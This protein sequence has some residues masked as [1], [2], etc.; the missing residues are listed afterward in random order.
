MPISQLN[1][2]LLWARSGNRCA[3]CK[4][5][6][7]LDA[8]EHDD[9]SVVGDECHIVA[10]RLDGA[11]GGQL[12]P[13]EVDGYA[14]LILLC[15]IDHKRVDDQ[16][17]E[18]PSEKL[19]AIKA[20]HEAWVYR[21]LECDVQRAGAPQT[22]TIAPGS[23]RPVSAAIRSDIFFSHRM[24]AAFPGVRGLEEIDQPNIA[25]DRISL[26][27][28][29]PLDQ[30]VREQNGRTFELN[31][32]WWFR[33][34]QSM[35]I[36]VFERLDG[37]RC[38][39]GVDQMKIRRI[40]AFRMPGI[41][42]REF[43]YIETHSESP[44]GVYKYPPGRIEKSLE[45]AHNHGYGG[46][47]V[48]E[49]ALWEGRPIT[50]AEYD[51]GAALINGTPTQVPSAEVR[52]RFLSPYNVLICGQRNVINNDANYDA[53]LDSVLDEILRRNAPLSV[54]ADLVRKL[55]IPSQFQH[56]V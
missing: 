22:S 16:P 51:D 1:R 49:Y 40:A 34:G 25:V 41:L 15:K 21:T 43:L 27:L 55:P 24:A 31:P 45:D 20:A 2:K 13:E 50:R 32:L 39:I 11:R 42:H 12:P 48:E 37:D 54:L 7:I 56:M 4:N 38:L 44:V 5:V 14:N 8:T 10:Q 46:Y 52:R 29:E 47:F 53:Q 36:D 33:G 3:L 30:L 26:I 35:P 6:L 19:R 23:E 28:G 17:N 18:F 9:E